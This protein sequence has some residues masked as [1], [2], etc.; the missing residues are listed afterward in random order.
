MSQP[1]H[2]HPAEYKNDR[3]HAFVSL[4]KDCRIELKVKTSSSLIKEAKAE[5]VKAVNKEAQLPGFRKGKA[6]DEIIRKKF[7]R[8]IEKELHSK[9]ANIA[10]QETQQLTKLAV[11]NRNAPVTFD[12]KNFSPEEAELLFSF[13]TEPNV[14]T[15]D[16]KSF[17]K[18]PVT[19]P[20]VAEKQID[21][22]IRQMQ[23]YFATW[24]PITD[25]PIQDKDT[26]IINLDTV[27]GETSHRVFNEV[28][29]EFIIL[30]CRSKLF[31]LCV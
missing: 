16:P 2:Q 21:E 11:L 27:E 4:Q 26:I 22:A 1:D 15:I 24:T 19:R 7:P 31:N 13:E 23:F 25:R 17:K 8:E 12:L 3:V 5:A 18:S 29:F 10:F 20:E 30:R 6:P 9:L 14:P 28:R